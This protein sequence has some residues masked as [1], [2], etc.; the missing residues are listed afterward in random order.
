M[1]HRS[2]LVFV[3]TALVLGLS[4]GGVAV[5][6]HWNSGTIHQDQPGLFGGTCD[7]AGKNWHSTAGYYRSATSNLLNGGA[8]SSGEVRHRY[9]SC[10]TTGCSYTLTSYVVDTNGDGWVEIAAPLTYTVGIDY[11]HHRHLNNS[12]LEINGNV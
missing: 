4:G 10:N 12:P 6:S 3:V 7:I 2:A 8:C 5:A 11:S 9:K 1:R